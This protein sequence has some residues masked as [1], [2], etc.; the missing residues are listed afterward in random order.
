MVCVCA[1]HFAKGKGQQFLYPKLLPF[2]SLAPDYKG[3]CVGKLW[4]M[5]ALGVS[6]HFGLESGKDTI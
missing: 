4:V 1:Q 2:L 3:C 6:S 5:T